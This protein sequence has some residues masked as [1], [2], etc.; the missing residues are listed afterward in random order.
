MRPEKSKLKNKLD[1]GQIVTGS[2]IFSWSPNMMEVAGYSGL[3]FMRIDTEHAWRRD[4]EIEHLIRAAYIA[5]VVPIIRIDGN[6][7]TLPGKI[8]E[9]GAG[10]IIVTGIETVEA[11]TQLVLHSKF[12]PRGTRGYS[13]NCWS[14]GWGAEAGMKWVEWSNRELLI[15]IMVENPET[16]DNVTDIMAVDGI[17]FA[18]FGP[19]DYSMALGLGKPSKNNK[20]V[21]NALQR[22]VS[23]ARKTG[24]HV[25][26]NPGI[27]WEE[28]DKAVKMGV[29][30]IEIGN[31][32]GVARSVWTS[33]VERFSPERQADK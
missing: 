27:K 10:G 15:G 22:T 33:T 32:L 6:D 3:D 11:A 19:A 20:D 28:I 25:M 9:V 13:G 31:D 4:A 14:G 8:F 17:D 2:A 21:Q 5:D 12:P 16:M 18:L 29:T 23:A 30:M 24:K 26:Y 7:S 1:K